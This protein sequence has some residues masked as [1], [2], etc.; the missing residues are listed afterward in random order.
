MFVDQARDI[1]NI[2]GGELVRKYLST[3]LRG[4][5]L[6]WYNAELSY[7]KKSALKYQKEP[8]DNSGIDL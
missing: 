3:C 2:K 8:R 4:T 5:A 6:E 1:V 7:L